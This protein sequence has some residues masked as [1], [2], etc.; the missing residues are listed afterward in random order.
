MTKVT[1]PEDIVEGIN[2]ISKEKK[3]KKEELVEK[4]KEIMK[5]D[6]VVRKVE[7]TATK[8]QVAWGILASKYVTTGGNG[9]D[10][11]VQ[12]LTVA[13]A[14][15]PKNDLI[16]DFYALA[17]LPKNKNSPVFSKFTAWRDIAEKVNDLSL[18][19]R[20]KVNA[21]VTDSKLGITG[22]LTD[23]SEIIEADGKLN[24]TKEFIEKLYNDPNIRCTIADAGRNVVDI[25]DD[26]NVRV[27]KGTVVRAGPTRDG[28]SAAF[29][30]IDKTFTNT[31]QMSGFTIYTNIDQ[32][33]S[34]VGSR[35]YFTGKIGTRK[36]GEDVE[37][38]M[39]N[40]IVTPLVLVPFEEGG[41]DE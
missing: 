31:K 32:L 5:G 40:G 17:W 21:R 2:K 18:D 24:D 4:L 10:V 30:I 14:R 29:T 12:P 37:V 35:C 41:S 8:V 27:I 22:I 1:I 3:V 23:T 11:I 33:A 39:R 6:A 26:L 15:K 28:K 20:Y 7:D 36:K 9:M 34:G 19:K 25:R 38:L 16:A 13:E